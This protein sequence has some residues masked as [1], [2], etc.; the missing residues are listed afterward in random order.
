LDSMGIKKCHICIC[1]YW[2]AVRSADLLLVNSGIY[3]K[4][5]IYLKRGR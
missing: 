4:V 3:L 1:M 2:A 5:L